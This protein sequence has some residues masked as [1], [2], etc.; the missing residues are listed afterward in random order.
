MPISSINNEPIAVGID[1][2]T[3][4][5]A[6][7][8]H[9]LLGEYMDDGLT[10]LPA[11]NW[12]NGS[13]QT[14]SSSPSYGEIVYSTHTI[15]MDEKGYASDNVQ[16]FCD[17]GW[18][19][20][21]IP[22]SGEADSSCIYGS[23]GYTYN[24]LMWKRV[25]LIPK[26]IYYRVAMRKDPHSSS[27]VLDPV[28]C[29]VHAHFVTGSSVAFRQARLKP[30]D[31]VPKMLWKL[32][33]ASAGIPNWTKNTHLLSP[34]I[35][36]AD[37]PIKI[38][39]DDTVARPY[40]YYYDEDGTY[41]T[42]AQGASIPKGAYYR[43]DLNVRD[44]SS[45]GHYGMT[46]AVS[47]LEMEDNFIWYGT[48]NG[49]AVK[50]T[51][52]RIIQCMPVKYDHPVVISLTDYTTYRVGTYLRA[53]NKT[54]STFDYEAL[55]NSPVGVPAGQWF[56]IYM[57]KVGDA[58]F[59][60]EDIEEAVS[61]LRVEP[62]HGVGSAVDG[63]R[64]ELAVLKRRVTELEGETV[65]DYYESESYSLSGKI[66]DI[67]AANQQPKESVVQFAFVTDFHANAYSQSFKTRALL[68]KVFAETHCS[69]LVNGGDVM[70]GKL[71]SDNTPV[72]PIDFAKGMQEWSQWL[73]PDT[74]S[75]SLMVVGNHDGGVDYNPSTSARI[76]EH[77]LYDVS[78]L[79][80]TAG[81]VVLDPNSKCSYYVDDDYHSIRW[82]VCNV[83][84]TSNVGKWSTASSGVTG[85]S[86]SDAISFAGQSL[87]SMPSGWTAIVINHILI[88]TWT[89]GPTKGAKDLEDLCDLFKSRGS[90]TIQG[91][92]FDFSDAYGDIACLVGGHL[93][94]D[95]DYATDGGI[96][97][98]I[99]TTDNRAGQC[100]LN[101]QT[102]KLVID[103]SIRQGGTPD[104]QAFDVFT[105]DT[106]ERTISTVRIG[107][108][109]DRSWEY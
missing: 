97:C 23:T 8:I 26:G 51:N 67:L 3:D 10:S 19:L 13:V 12:T 25:L 91:R 109:V 106:S 95:Y 104:E 71:T 76:D 86:V 46:Y 75:L 32:G 64:N 100:R 85:E 43:I 47:L 90:G 88:N 89:N 73:V 11:S 69:M 93:H 78:A 42:Y 74:A 98:I 30:D 2:F 58:A 79:S 81:N 31:I 66:A 41:L 61:M 96:P 14:N 22:Y 40:V 54:V 33:E 16:V 18:L 29:H 92:F 38:T 55:H 68:N 49:N 52:T 107:Y 53:D 27:N 65:P 94:I 72:S 39:Y 20:G 59:T 70:N 50:Y 44:G 24:E 105:I 7:D 4:D 17:S 6:T 60:V 108:G 56:H 102:N 36:H 34:E 28:E 103:P 63:V 57:G 99:V 5:L 77:T 80:L 45:Q 87:G 37:K 101:E 9:N 82:I 1:G 21:F 35:M 84:N 83:G 48:S 62:I 15:I